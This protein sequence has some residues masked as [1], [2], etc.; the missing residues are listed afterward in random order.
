VNLPL[1]CADFTFPLLEHDQALQLISMLRVEGVD[2]GLFEN[3]SHLWPSREFVHTAS[4]AKRLKERFDELSLRPADIFLQMDP[5][6]VAHAINH[7]D[8]NCREKARDWFQHALEYARTLGCLHVTALPGADFDSEAHEDSLGRA[9]DELAWRVE[10]S[11]AMGVVFGT[12]AHVGSIATTPEG[13]AELIEKV[14]GL[15]LTLD[16]THFTKEGVRD[17]R[18]EPLVKYASHFHVRGARSGRLQAG[19]EQ[20]TIDYERVLTAMKEADYRGWLGLEYVWTDWEHCNECDNLCESIRYRDY[21]RE[22][23]Q[24]LGD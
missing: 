19:F 20:N 11:Q 24:T 16:Y 1:A 21:L 2:I 18:I 13:A 12:E 7:P 3:R 15:T 8:T 14:P 23:M 6:F 22:T 4:A 9:I 17:T 5:D 10:Q